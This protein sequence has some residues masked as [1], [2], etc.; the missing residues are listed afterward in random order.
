MEEKEF[1]WSL[2]IKKEMI[3]PKKKVVIKTEEDLKTSGKS[4][5][6]EVI[7]LKKEKE[8]DVA[9]ASGKEEDTT[10][11]S[12]KENTTDASGKEKEV[13]TVEKILT[14]APV[15]RKVGVAEVKAGISSLVLF[16]AM[17]MIVLFS[18]PPH[19]PKQSVARWVTGIV[20]VAT[21][22]FVV[23]SSMFETFIKEYVLTMFGSEEDDRKKFLLAFIETDESR[24]AYIAR[25]GIR[26]NRNRIWIE[27]PSAYIVA[28]DLVVSFS[29]REMLTNRC[30]TI[31]LDSISYQAFNA[32]DE[33]GRMC[34]ISKKLGATA[35]EFDLFQ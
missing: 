10:D 7:E 31:V 13:L 32:T 25:S 24:D 9:N 33:E 34:M 35:M 1:E 14:N 6:V 18:A 30:C 28:D 11:A 5:E 2:T 15:N 17:L 4:D 26:V 20:G 12:G 21:I 29:F 8:E 27:N 19:T 3:K 23:F 22:L 16:F